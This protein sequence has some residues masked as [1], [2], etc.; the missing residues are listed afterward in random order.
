MLS[1]FLRKGNESKIL[2]EEDVFEPADVD[3]VLDETGI[4]SGPIDLSDENG[5]YNYPIFQNDLFN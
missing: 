5:P 1:I 4:N 3:L 2:A